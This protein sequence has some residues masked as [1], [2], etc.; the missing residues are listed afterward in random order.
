MSE[1]E[2]LESLTAK[3]REL[4]PPVSVEDLEALLEMTE[5]LGH[6]RNRARERRRRLET[7]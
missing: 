1:Q 6:I 5:E 7:I 4:L 3:L 2:Q